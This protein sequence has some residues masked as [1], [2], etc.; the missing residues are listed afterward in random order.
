MEGIFSL[1]TAGSGYREDSLGE[2]LPFLGLIAK[3]DLPPLD[4]RTNGPFRNIIGGLHPLVDEESKKMRPVVEEPLSPSAHLYIRAAQ[5]L[6]A[7]S[8]HPSPHQ[9][10]SVEELLP[11]DVAFTEG[12]P[13]TEDPPRFLE[14]V[15]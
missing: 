3:A 9:G 11:G 13:T 1:K 10:G 8:F 7:V 15:L 4:G 6:P 5:I 12:M 2:S 14:H